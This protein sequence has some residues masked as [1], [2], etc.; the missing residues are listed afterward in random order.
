MIYAEANIY[1]YRLHIFIIDIQSDCVEHEIQ[2]LD[3]SPCFATLLRCHKNEINV[4]FKTNLVNLCIN[5]NNGLQP[6]VL[7]IRI[8]LRIYQFFTDLVFASLE[9]KS[10]S[11][12]YAKMLRLEGDGNSLSTWIH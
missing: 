5:A 11:S 8:C 3:I 1:Y 12:L 6:K 7:W 2:I 4:N 10:S 9:V